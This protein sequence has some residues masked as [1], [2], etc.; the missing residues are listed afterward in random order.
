MP[1]GVKFVGYRDG[2]RIFPWGEY[3]ADAIMQIPEKPKLIT[4]EARQ[5]RN[6]KHLNLY[7]KIVNRVAENDPELTDPQDLHD[8][9]KIRLGMFKEFKDW[10]GRILVRAKSISVEAMDQIHFK[11]FYDRAMWL[12]SERIG[13]SPEELLDG[14]QSEAA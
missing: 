10:D 5:N 13:M 11:N 1:A 6:P 8:W 7:W 3:S 2:G 9:I 12:L 4:F 14:E